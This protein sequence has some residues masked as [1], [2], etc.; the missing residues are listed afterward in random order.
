MPKDSQSIYCFQLSIAD[1]AGEGVRD[2]GGAN[3]LCR[4][5]RH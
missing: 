1:C 3:V 4:N 2:L 5:V